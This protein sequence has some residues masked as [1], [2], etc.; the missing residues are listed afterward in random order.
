LVMLRKLLNFLSRIR[1]C[2]G[3]LLEQ[4]YTNVVYNGVDARLHWVYG[5]MKMPYEFFRLSVNFPLNH[6]FVR[7]DFPAYAS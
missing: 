4:S 1:P 6:D 2:G 5:G 3:V 7:V